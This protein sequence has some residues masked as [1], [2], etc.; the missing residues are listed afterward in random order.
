MSSHKSVEF[1]SHRGPHRNPEPSSTPPIAHTKARRYSFARWICR[2][3]NPSVQDTEQHEKPAAIPVIVDITMHTSP[4]SISVPDV[5]RAD[6][7][8]KACP[9]RFPNLH[10]ESSHRSC[11]ASSCSLT[12]TTPPDASSYRRM[13]EAFPFIP[14]DFTVDVVPAVA[15]GQ[16]STWH[17]SHARASYVEDHSACRP[18]RNTSADRKEMSEDNALQTESSKTAD[19]A[20]SSIGRG[21]EGST[22]RPHTFYDE[23]SSMYHPS[24]AKGSM[25]EH[26]KNICLP[27]GSEDKGHIYYGDCTETI[28]APSGSVHE[29][30]DAE[31]QLKWKKYFDR[32]D[33]RRRAWEGEVWLS[34]VSTM[35]Y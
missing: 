20:K 5:L 21:L 26:S 2:A 18:D 19:V 17:I 33:E 9:Y 27:D 10:A 35:L 31:N 11:E 14:K 4:V 7:G 6:A 16:R 30:T 32:I 24:T 12:G 15:N 25:Q 23:A 22:S 34:D 28:S 3:C 13:L 8:P 1:G 29:L